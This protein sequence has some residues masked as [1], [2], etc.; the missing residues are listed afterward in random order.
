[1]K[2][3]IVKVFALGWMLAVYLVITLTFLTAYGNP[4]KTVTVAIDH[5]NEAD[6]ELIMLLGG[7]IFVGL[8]SFYFF[9]ESILDFKQR[10]IQNR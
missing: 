7:F 5:Y 4:S 9:T 3:T 2:K 10:T 6:I 1:M 8:G